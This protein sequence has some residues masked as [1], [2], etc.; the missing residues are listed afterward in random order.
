MLTHFI[1]TFLDKYLSS[2]SVVWAVGGTIALA[3]FLLFPVWAVATIVVM[4][5]G[6]MLFEALFDM[7]PVTDVQFSP[8]MFMF[9]LLLCDISPIFLF[10]LLKEKHQND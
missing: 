9:Y 8:Q 1:F 7:R 10:F 2:P 5:Q 3:A 4:F 6:Q